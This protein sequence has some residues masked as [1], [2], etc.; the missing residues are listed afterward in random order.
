MTGP[1]LIG[2]KFRRRTAR[3]RS[4]VFSPA[5]ENLDGVA[6]AGRCVYSPSSYFSF[7]HF[8]DDCVKSRLKKLYVAGAAEGFCIFPSRLPSVSAVLSA[9]WSLLHA[10]CHSE[11][12]Q[13]AY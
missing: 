3:R 13:P 12:L 2:P 6:A 1:P 10:G 7:F 9:G 4:F 11:I 5:A 8:M